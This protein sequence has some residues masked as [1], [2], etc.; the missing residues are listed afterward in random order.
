MTINLDEAITAG[1][2][3]YREEYPHGAVSEELEAQANLTGTPGDVAHT[4]TISY[5]VAGSDEPFI[6]FQASVDATTGQVTVE[7]AQAAE[8]LSSLELDERKHV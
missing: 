5:S 7:V 8:S 2:K 4:V 3:K 1:L 6:L